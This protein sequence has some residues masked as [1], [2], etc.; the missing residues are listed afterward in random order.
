LPFGAG[1]RTVCAWVATNSLTGVS[2]IFDT[3]TTQTDQFFG[4]GRSGASLV[5]F[6]WSDDITAPNFFSTGAWSHVCLAYD[7]KTATLYG[8]GVQ[9]AQVAKAW[10][11]V[12]SGGT[13]IGNDYPNHAW[14]GSIDEVSYYTRA[15]SAAEISDLYAHYGY[16][17]PGDQGHELVRSYS[18]P[19]P[20]TTAGQELGIYTSSGTWQS[21]AL[22][23]ENNLGW[24]DGSTDSSTAFSA[25]VLNVSSTATIQFQIRVASSVAGL[26]SAS[27]VS[28][29][30]VTGNAPFTLTKAQF[31]ASGLSTGPGEYIQIEVVLTSTGTNTNTPQLDGCTVYYESGS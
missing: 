4:L 9:L 3:G 17:T 28:L 10:N 19:E 15:L 21:N 11:T 24:G 6:G 2:E 16:A 25:T 31:D 29:G 5:G 22:S 12:D 14:N 13:F 30:T 27:Y 26:A 8:N 7:G 1:A 23:L 18:A 20:A